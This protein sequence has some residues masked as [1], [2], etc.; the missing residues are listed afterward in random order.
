MSAAGGMTREQM[1]RVLAS[2]GATD[3][4]LEA[5]GFSGQD[6]TIT[7]HDEIIGKVLSARRNRRPLLAAY[8][9]PEARIVLLRHALVSHLHACDMHGL[10]TR[11]FRQPKCEGPYRNCILAVAVGERAPESFAFLSWCEASS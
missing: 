5:E 9:T 4:A 3:D 6:A 1:C 7:M 8:I 2:I 10:A 11:V